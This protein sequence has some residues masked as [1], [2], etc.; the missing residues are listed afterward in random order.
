MTRRCSVMRMPVAAQRASISVGSAGADFSAVIFDSSP[1]VGCSHSSS[2]SVTMRILRQVA[3]HQQGICGFLTALPVIV[4][5]AS[6]DGKP[7]P[8]VEPPGRLVVLFYLQKYRSHTPGGE[9]AKVGQQQGVREPAATVAWS[10]RNRQDFGLIGTHARYRKADNFPSH[11]Q[12]MNQRVFFAQHVLE[13]AFTPAAVKG[14]AM[15]SGERRR[16]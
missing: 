16:V 13:F 6:D 9:V 15:N 2:F 8:L 1:G 7:R 5:A 14:R 11:F 4:L 3:P 12:P 10:H